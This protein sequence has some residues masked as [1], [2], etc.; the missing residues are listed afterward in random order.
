MSEV[1]L[2][3]TVARD[4]LIGVA[5]L[6]G[7]ALV[8]VAGWKWGRALFPADS[9]LSNLVHAG[10]ISW[11]LIVVT[12]MVL[13]LAGFLTG[14]GLLSAVTGVAGGSLVA[15][16][17]AR[18]ESAARITWSA[19][20]L[21]WL[22]GW[23]G[24][25]S[26][27]AAHVLTRGL[28]K[29][30]S[31]WD[32]VY[33]HIPLIDHWLQAGSL[34]APDSMRWSDPGNNEVLGL[35]AVGP[36]S[37]DFL[38]CLSNLPAALILAAGAVELGTTIG[39]S[40]PL[41]HLAGFLV[42]SH[43]AVLHQLANA[44]NDVAVVALFFPA[45][46]YALRYLENPSWPNLT[47]GALCVGL[48]AGVKFYALGYAFV[49]VVTWL[50]L[51]RGRIRRNARGP[52]SHPAFLANAATRADAAPAP[53]KG[54][55]G[56]KRTVFVL[57]ALSAGLVL[58]SG[59]WYLRNLVVT[60]SPLYPK[61]FFRQPDVLTLINPDLGYTSFLG[62]RRPELPELFLEAVWKM[63]GPG[64]LTALLLVPLSA[65]WL[66]ASGCWIYRRKRDTIDGSRRIA[67]AL[68]LCAAGAVLAV[69]PAAVE[70]RPG[71][72]NQLRW[73]Y[74]PV[75]YGLCF[76]NITVLA[77]V[78]C[79]RDLLAPLRA[80]R[81]V[82]LRVLPFLLHVLLLG[83]VGIQL[84]SAIKLEQVAWL[85]GVLVAANVLLARG[86]VVLT[87]LTWPRLRRPL[88][89]VMITGAM[90]AWS[91][92]CG[93]LSERWHEGFTAYYQQ[94]LGVPNLRDKAIAE[95][96][97]GKICVLE[98]RAYPFFGSRRQHRLCQPLYVHSPEWLLRYLREN[99]V[100][101]VVGIR[102]RPPG[103]GCFP[104]FDECRAR[105]PAAFAEIKD[106]SGGFSVF[107]FKPQAFDE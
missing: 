63:M 11:A 23:A 67:L 50:V 103:P 69:T 91:C 71:T 52:V 78:L 33:Y 72:L 14:L 80:A 97:Q 92:L 4:A 43:F 62:N 39:L 64:H 81:R 93:F 86:I 68:V 29:F 77:G 1:V 60:G 13:G 106:V 25:A 24:L 105:Y 51:T 5:W 56:W 88:A 82:P 37:G 96:L 15:L 49:V 21:A 12:G 10:V 6:L 38:V 75:R 94:L 65:A 26:F 32:S 89:F 70:D 74:C 17:L 76:L 35:W 101:L 87:G 57:G 90:A 85:D 2:E 55:L 47:L 30:P 83:A 46:W 59:Y 48:L 107:A 28:L 100:S 99:N 53:N 79:L 73:G 61:D 7:S 31:D 16:R 41:A 84:V 40:R 104:W 20:E 19:R 27:W 102:N 42:V 66:L 36:Y 45:L 44:E 9:L 22:A 34:Y 58:V 54:W 8:L 3:S 95:H 18:V 98:Y